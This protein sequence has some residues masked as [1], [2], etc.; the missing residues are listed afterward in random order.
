[1]GFI[2]FWFFSQQSV[3][4]KAQEATRI[5]TGTNPCLRHIQSKLCLYSAIPSDIPALIGFV[6]IITLSILSLVKRKP[7]RRTACS[8]GGSER[9]RYH[10]DISTTATWTIKPAADNST[11]P[12]CLPQTRVGIFEFFWGGRKRPCSFFQPFPWRATIVTSL[13]VSPGGTTRA[14]LASLPQDPHGSRDLSDFCLFPA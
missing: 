8:S 6:S 9:H 12:S 7:S 11:I 2:V 1:M 4:S 14:V 10:R 13:F 3:L 5:P